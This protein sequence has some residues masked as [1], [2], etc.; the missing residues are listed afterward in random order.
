MLRPS[1][2]TDGDGRAAITVLFQDVAVM[3]VGDGV[4]RG[5]TVRVTDSVNGDAE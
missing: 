4:D 1:G 3:L 5:Q 2:Q